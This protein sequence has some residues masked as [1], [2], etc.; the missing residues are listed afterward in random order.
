MNKRAN[1][2]LSP[3][4]LVLAACMATGAAPAPPALRVALMDF[5]THDNSWRNTQAAANFTSLLQIQLANE[6]GV[7]WVERAQL[8]LARQEIKLSD[9]DLIGGASPIRRG[10]WAKADWLVTGH[11]S[12]DDKSQHT[13]FLE[14]TD[15]QHADVLASQTI[16]FPGQ[17]APQ[18]EP[19]QDQVKL[20]ARAL[21]E[22][23]AKAGHRQ[24][25]TKDKV[26]VAPLF[27]VNLSRFGFSRGEDS[28]PRG[29]TE[30]LER[31]A[32]T[33]RHVR[34]I[35]FPKAYQAM[36]ESEMVLDGLVEADP[37]AWQQTAD[38]YVWGSYAV[39]N[40]R[41]GA[42]FQSKLEIMLHLWDGS[43]P[44]QTLREE[45]PTP[46]WEALPSNMTVGRSALDNRPAW[47]VQPRHTGSSAA[48]R[49]RPPQV[50]NGE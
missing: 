17:A 13:L 27:L 36:D 39:T 37:Q 2:L 18:V 46:Q 38:L 4:L 9:M 41:T 50:C 29:F 11:F 5:S 25:E 48:R 7:D 19:A 10:R 20:A 8:D 1:I 42:T 49:R 33:N 30:A 44:P 12:L 14:I 32:A 40:C 24:R 6:P 34:F 21:H 47:R 35:R 23:L 15:L 28:L 16:T 31:A 22:L 3:L 45:L 43:S 26:L